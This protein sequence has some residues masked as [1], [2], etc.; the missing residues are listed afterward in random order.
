MRMRK[1]N[2]AGN[3]LADY[4]RLIG[5]SVAKCHYSVSAVRNVH[6]LDV[7]RLV[8]VNKVI[9]R[10]NPTHFTKYSFGTA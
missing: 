3:R 8:K 10:L 5:L 7:N 9:H 2:K 6:F 4:N 1:R